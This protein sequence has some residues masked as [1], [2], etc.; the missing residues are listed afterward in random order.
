[1]NW[2]KSHSTLQIEP[3]R[4]C[5]LNCEICLRRGLKETDSLLSLENFKKVLNSWKFQHVALHGWGEPLL[6]PAIF[7][8]VGY[9]KS[10]KISTELTTN[11]TLLQAN[12]EKIFSSG[13]DIIVFGI[14]KKENLPVVFPQIN[15]LIVQR[16]KN[17]STK[18]KVYI[19]TAIY[20]RNHNEI[21]ELIKDANELGIDS[22]VLHRVFN[23]NNAGPD[24]EYISHQ[25]EKDLFV[26]AKRLAKKLKTE[27]YLPPAPCIPC[28]AVRLSVFVTSNGE[29]SPCPYLCKDCVGDALNKGV[30]EVIYSKK[31]IK[32]IKNM[33]K[34]PICT[35]CPLGSVNGRFYSSRE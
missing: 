16:N 8:M 4:R 28:N 3:T 24:F 13:L 2:S 31:Y 26:K 12:I 33:G 1:M 9:A 21:P 15:E 10:R 22:L 35:R 6:N 7:D 18:P 27:L 20:R 25:E 29:I 14:H 32:F 19:D 30:K 11:G 34:H 17:R 23:I 5:N